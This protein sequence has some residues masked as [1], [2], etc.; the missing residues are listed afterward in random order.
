M[1]ADV[2]ACTEAEVN[3]F[4]DDV[5]STDKPTITRMCRVDSLASTVAPGSPA[6]T[7]D[8]FDEIPCLSIRE[9]HVDRNADT[10]C[11]E[12][13]TAHP[14]YTS[15]L[16]S[17]VVKMIRRSPGTSLFYAMVALVLAGLIQVYGLKLLYKPDEVVCMQCIAKSVTQSLKPS[18]AK[19]H[20]A[21]AMVD[22]S[23]KTTFSSKPSFIKSNPLKKQPATSS[24]S[25]TPA[26]L[27]DHKMESSKG[28]VSWSSSDVA[29]L[30]STDVSALNAKMQDA[31]LQ[32]LLTWV[33][34]TLPNW[35]VFTSFGPSGLVVLKEL[36][37]MQLLS[38]V[39][40]CTIDTLHL[41]SETYDHIAQVEAQFGFKAKR[42]RPVDLEGRELLSAA[43]FANV[44]GAELWKHDPSQY[45]QLTKVAPMKRALKELDVSAHLTGRRAVQGDERAEM[46]TIEL[47]RQHLRINPVAF[48]SQ[49]E[50]WAYIQREAVP[51]NR[52]HDQG[53]LSIGDW[54]TTSQ[55]PEGGSERSGRW[56][57]GKQTECGMHSALDIISGGNF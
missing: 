52:L 24:G 36:A 5:G 43:D 46:T 9:E 3:P 26:S 23:R 53:Y 15:C 25:S 32:E 37:K 34:Q 55:T 7:I 16:N 12:S 35:V 17:R 56:L 44:Y 41:F 45:S 51:Y 48:W 21:P 42:F 39:T 6:S 4:E 1:F 54:P 28:Q 8:D 49:D 27:M 50:I 57:G 33:D 18:W 29:A 13:S 38:R 47:V 20:T 30:T 40:I 10:L 19:S 22:E 31:P 2:F 14:L 11:A